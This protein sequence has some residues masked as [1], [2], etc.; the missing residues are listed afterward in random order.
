MTPFLIRSGRP[1]RTFKVEQF[2]SKRI[3]GEYRPFGNCKAMAVLHK[4]KMVA[5]VIFHNWQPAEGVIEIS[6]ASD[7]KLWL[8]RPVLRAMFDYCFDDC[9]CQVVVMRISA[10]DEP[11]KR[12]CKSFGWELVTLPRLR[13][14]DHD[15]VGCFLYDDVWAKHPVNLKR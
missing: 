8:T 11:M 12:I 3:W 1:D 13:G 5:G 10:R 9:G 2:V 7:S 6:A 15:E 4:D 14:R